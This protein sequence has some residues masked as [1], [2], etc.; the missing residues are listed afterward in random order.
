MEHTGFKINVR[1]DGV[2]L[3]QA[4]DW[5]IL[6][7][8]LTEIALG[9]CCVMPFHMS[10]QNPP[11]R[12][13]STFLAPTEP[14][15]LPQVTI[16]HSFVILSGNGHMQATRT[17]QSAGSHLWVTSFSPLCRPSGGEPDRWRGGERM[18][19]LCRMS[20]CNTSS[21]CVY[22]WGNRDGDHICLGDSQM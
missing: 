4:A 5:Q 21:R 10:L 11:L 19:E 6:S 8:T 15:P 12:I 7:W 18:G 22:V 3:Q 9:G 2:E 1:P 13:C 14:P 16:W 17:S 20:V